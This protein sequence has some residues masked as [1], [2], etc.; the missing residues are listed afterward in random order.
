MKFVIENNGGVILP[1]PSV[2]TSFLIQAWADDPCDDRLLECCVMNIVVVPFQYILDCV[3]QQDM[4]PFRDWAQ[5]STDKS[6]SHLN[7]IDFPSLYQPALEAGPDARYCCILGALHMGNMDIR[8]R[9]NEEINQSVYE[10]VQQAWPSLGDDGRSVIYIQPFQSSSPKPNGPQGVPGC[11][12]IGSSLLAASSVFLASYFQC[13]VRVLDTVSINFTSDGASVAGQSVRVFDDGG[14]AK[15]PKPKGK[16]KHKVLNTGGGSRRLL[17]VLDLLD[18]VEPLL[19]SDGYCILGITDE[20]IY[21]W[22]GDG[23]SIPP[24]DHECLQGLMRGR[25]FGGSRIAVFSSSCYEDALNLAG[26]C[27]AQQTASHLAYQLSTMAH[28]AMHCF[29]LD[30]CGLY[31]CCMNSWSDEIQEFARK[32]LANKSQL[33]VEGGGVIGCLHVCPICVRK[34]QVTCGFDLG[35]RY[36]SLRQTYS[37]MGLD[38]QAQWCAAVIR[39]AKERDNGRP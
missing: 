30:H 23:S 14:N 27:S 13:E 33:K 11:V 2:H 22:D 21:E 1:K 18:T 26:S 6:N 38:E 16:R 34:L 10:H 4:V 29:G 39:C 37:S 17:D 3:A 15:K 31:T 20:L 7:P 25:A 36:E 28:E 19:P 32:P 8:G 9:E 12:S 24:A 35:G 5:L